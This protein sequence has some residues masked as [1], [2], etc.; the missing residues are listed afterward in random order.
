MTM[1]RGLRIPLSFF[2]Q[3]TDR[4]A[5]RLLGQ[6]L[7]HVVNGRRLSGLIIETEAYLGLEDPACH[8]FGGRKTAR[9]KTLYAEP[10]T[11]YVYLIYGLHSCFNVVTRPEGVPEAVLIRALIPDEG[12]EVQKQNRRSDRLENLCS[13]PGKLCEALGITRAQN[14]LRLDGESLFIERAQMP[15]F[16]VICSPRIG[17]DYAGDAAKWPLRF[18]VRDVNKVSRSQHNPS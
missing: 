6:R 2:A 5:R 13:G 9:T 18:S 16:E 15:K 4:V 17:I 14:G 10:G 11:S 7:V 1:A 3:K 8:S 12:I